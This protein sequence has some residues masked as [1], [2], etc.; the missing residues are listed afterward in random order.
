MSSRTYRNF[1]I[2]FG[3][4]LLLWIL[5]SWP[6]VQD[7]A[8]I[9]LRY[10]VNLLRYHFISYDGIHPDYGT[11]SLF[12]V[13]LLA[14]LRT[15]F[16]SPVLP[17]A[18]SS[19]FHVALF[20]G[21]AWGFSRALRSAPRLAW[22]F[23][24]LMLAILVTPMAV[25]W[26]DDGMETSL[27]LCLISLLVFAL[28]RLGRSEVLSGRSWI[29]LF[30]LGLI[31]TLTRVEYLLL[32][33]IA[34]ATLLFAR[35]AQ[36]RPKSLS[37]SV[38]IGAAS[39]APLLGSLLAAG[40]IYRSM[41]ALVP[42]TAIAKAE[43]LAPWRSTMGSTVDVFVSAMSMG[44]ILLGFW[45]LTAVAV[46]V[47]QRRVSL[48]LLVANSP[49]PIV[50]ALAV[51]RGQQVQG[52]RYFVWTLVFPILWNILELRWSASEPHRVA[53]RTV[54]FGG[55]A[56]VLALLIVLPIESVLLFREF[57]EREKSF[58]QFRSQHL[59]RLSSMKL[60]AFDVGYIG[61]F[62]QSPLC[63]MAGLVNGR[64]SAALPFGARV[65][66]CAAQQ[67]P[68]AFVSDFSIWELGTALDIRGWSICSEYNF[69]NLR[70][71]DFH[72]LIAS[73]AATAK[74]CAAAGNAPR[75]LD[76]VFHPHAPIDPPVSTSP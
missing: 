49:F 58:A 10:A 15:L 41:H 28:S 36:F 12:Y 48:A 16:Q 37:A 59:E 17:R 35:L 30:A 69:A 60:V 62:T 44:A 13:F 14:T 47:Y 66:A 27:T 19:V 22:G 42:D 34:S 53:I 21:L 43:A 39:V 64:A 74:V 25:R 2:A 76:D 56:V 5:L 75:P 71:P 6:S 46:I 72:Y 70:A 9:H 61:Y 32:M 23:A 63:D 40:I 73:P 67:P 51:Q 52:V 1:A 54:A 57:R 3:V 4:W 68:Y 7:D 65:K 20:G 29:W 55:Y 38:R 50:L 18:V 45:L 8:F 33:A 24:A 31:S 11:S 26:L